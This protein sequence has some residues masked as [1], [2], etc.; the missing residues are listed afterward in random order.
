MTADM[1]S[2][3]ME[4]MPF[5]LLLASIQKKDVQKLLHPL[6][7]AA[8]FSPAGTKEQ[9]FFSYTETPHNI[10]L[11]LD[12]N[13]VKL[14]EDFLGDS[15]KICP[16]VWRC[17]QVFAGQSG[18]HL[19]ELSKTIQMISEPFA[20]NEISIYQLSTVSNDFTLVPEDR[21]RDAVNCLKSQFRIINLE[22]VLG[23]SSSSDEQTSEMEEFKAKL[24]AAE[25]ECPRSSDNHDTETIMKHTV[26]EPVKGPVHIAS[27]RDP[28]MASL[29]VKGILGRVMF[30]QEG[31][32]FSFT[33]ID[34]EY[35]LV[36]DKKALECYQNSELFNFLD[37]Q[38]SG[39][40]LIEIGNE[41]NDGLGFEESGIV[42]KYSAS[43]A[44]S[45]INCFYISTFLTDYVLVPAGER[46][47]NESQFEQ[48]KAL[49]MGLDH[50]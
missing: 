44:Q 36:L 23:S 15:V 46:S 6:L 50:Q 1:E 27:L 40:H 26:K 13:S 37:S 12:M 4:I 2:L 30:P 20:K 25:H 43:L 7:Q 32:F 24:S 16:M 33:S 21:L 38:Q 10:S 34:S 14:F 28:T 48:A 9:H 42:A 8:F 39:W 47:M 11:I 49:L 35:S 17:V 29:I 5:R 18:T 45:G 22:D 3:E 19:N 31:S 41:S